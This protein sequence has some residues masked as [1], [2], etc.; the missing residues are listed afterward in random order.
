MKDLRDKAIRAGSVKTC[1]Q[2][3]CLLLRVASLIVL[4]RL[5]D[6]RDFGL[7]GMATAFSGALAPLRDLGLSVT[8]IQQSRITND[9]SSAL[10]WVN[11]FIGGALTILLSACAHAIAAFYQDAQLTWI[12]VALATGFLLTGAGVQHAALLKRQLR[13]KVLAVID[14][15]SL[16]A[17][18]GIAIEMAKGG[19]GY[20]A[21][22]AMTVGVPFFTTIGA[23]V[24]AAWI[25]GR[26]RRDAGIRSMVRF[27]GIVTLNSVIA[28]I[29]S[30]V[31]KVLLGRV[32]G[33]EALGL[34]GRASQLIGVPT[35]NINLAVGDVAF[36]ALSR[37]QEDQVRLKRYFLRCY[38]L[39]V[40]LTLPA[41]V[42]C[43]VFA[44]D[45]TYVLLGPKWIDAADY[46]RYLA[47]TVVVFSIANP[48]SWQLYSLGR[49]NQILRIALLFAP[50]KVL[51]IAIGLLY[52][53]KGVA[54]GYSAVMILG[55]LPVIF[56]SVRGTVVRIQDV[57][58][59]LCRPILSTV[60]AVCFTLGAVYLYG[61]IA[62]P[63]IRLVIEVAL[64]GSTYLVGLLFVAG[65]KSIYSQLLREIGRSAWL[66]V[67]SFASRV[68][69]YFRVMGTVNNRGGQA[70]D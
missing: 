37:I 63:A 33:A 47:P 60:A 1:A 17:S 23:W 64:F 52:G 44:D 7:V 36:A 18:I 14:V 39:V 21:L 61:S 38:S 5:L 27:G 15:I 53:P 45:V 56:F 54:L 32:W 11:L 30:N 3:A 12:T 16:V 65:H 19:F 6:P 9:Q 49:F 4:A 2:A 35:E 8:S 20:W 13:F 46:F 70:F 58:L 69:R 50:F 51:G 55:A 34:Y 43:A 24:A 68:T 31:D 29:A 57:L 28:Y 40:A 10:F 62:G 59:S 66:D 42:A 25:P 26:P 67:T 41:T 22:V 48:L